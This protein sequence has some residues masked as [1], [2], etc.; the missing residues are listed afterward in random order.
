MHSRDLEILRTG[1]QCGAIGAELNEI[2]RSH[3]LFGY[4]S[5]QHGHTFGVLCHY[6]RRESGLELCEDIDVVLRP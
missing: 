5:F 4:R 6:Y 1:T 2:Y 3:G